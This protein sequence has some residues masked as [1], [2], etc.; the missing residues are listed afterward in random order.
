MFL[1]IW[2]KL[3]VTE[4]VFNSYKWLTQVS[5]TFLNS[6]S[7]SSLKFF[8]FKRLPKLFSGRIRSIPFHFKLKHFSVIWNGMQATLIYVSFLFS[9]Q[10]YLN[11]KNKIL[12]QSCVEWV[13]WLNCNVVRHWHHFCG[14]L[15][16]NVGDLLS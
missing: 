9:T 4:K 8:S 15:V 2:L 5:V 16:D 3:F 6:S 1:I 13:S 11:F 14:V 12:T 10:L 7:F